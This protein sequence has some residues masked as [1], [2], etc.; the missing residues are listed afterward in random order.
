MC[1]LKYFLSSA[2]AT[3]SICSLSSLRAAEPPEPWS[4]APASVTEVRDPLFKRL[5]DTPVSVLDYG[6]EMTWRDLAD[7]AK[8]PLHYYGTDGALPA[9]VSVTYNAKE[10]KIWISIESNPGTEGGSPF[11]TKEKGSPA[12]MWCKTLIHKLRANMAGYPNNPPKWLQYFVHGSGHYASDATN[13]ELAELNSTLPKRVFLRAHSAAMGD[14]AVH[15]TG[16]L[17]GSEILIERE[18]TDIVE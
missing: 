3:V 2:I 7:A 18:P 5:S 11:P 16:S 9:R 15:C 14:D 12:E 10:N 17:I 8:E 13:A 4:P 1:R 6:L